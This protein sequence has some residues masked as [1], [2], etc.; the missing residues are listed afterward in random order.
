MPLAA[1]SVMVERGRCGFFH[2]AASRRE[3]EAAVSATSQ[4]PVLGSC[5]KKTFVPGA[6]RMGGGWSRHLLSSGS[7]VRSS[8]RL[9][10]TCSGRNTGDVLACGW[11]VGVDLGA[12]GGVV[13]GA[14]VGGVVWCWRT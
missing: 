8:E 6:A 1:A 5:R 3:R 14:V 11:F 12:V 7:L 4:M 13:V 10:R 2:W 9:P